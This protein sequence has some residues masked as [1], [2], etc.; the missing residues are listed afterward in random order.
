MRKKLVSVETLSGYRLRLVFED[1]EKR[2]FD[3]AP[4]LDT[5]IFR[6][7][8]APDV[9]R[10]VR[11]SFDT[12]CWANDAEICPDELREYSVAENSPGYGE[13]LRTD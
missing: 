8:R 6:E 10:S 1:G 11:I 12:I 2:I 3:V 4:Y 13:P 7:L 9:F 5:G